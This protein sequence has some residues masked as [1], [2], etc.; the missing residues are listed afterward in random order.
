MRS[1][2]ARGTPTIAAALTIATAASALADD[3]RPTG[4]PAHRPS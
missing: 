3:N 4:A 2:H 1:S